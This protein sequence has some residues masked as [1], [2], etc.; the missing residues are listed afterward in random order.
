MAHAAAG[1]ASRRKGQGE[2]GPGLDRTLQ[3]FGHS[4]PF[5]AEEKMVREEW[6][7]AVEIPEFSK[8]VN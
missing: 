4:V 7:Y 1:M 3:R 6:E 2:G 8:K 5:Y